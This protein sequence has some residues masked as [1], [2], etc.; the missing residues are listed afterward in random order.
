M[1]FCE[2]L[3]LILLLAL[4]LVFPFIDFENSPLLGGVLCGFFRF[5]L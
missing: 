3:S 2:G 1:L 5:C 4:F